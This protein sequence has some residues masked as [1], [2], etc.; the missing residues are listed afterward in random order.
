MYHVKVLGH[1]YNCKSY[2]LNVATVLGSKHL[3]KWEGERKPL[4]APHP[5][6]SVKIEHQ[7]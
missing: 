3:G 4:L 6:G 5:L 1:S 7:C 2:F